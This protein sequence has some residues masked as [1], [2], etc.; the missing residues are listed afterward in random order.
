MGLRILVFHKTSCSQ[1]EPIEL[2]EALWTPLIKKAVM[3]ALQES[4]N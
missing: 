2:I 3:H 4:L 1:I